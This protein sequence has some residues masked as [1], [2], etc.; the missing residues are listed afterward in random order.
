MRSGLPRTR[1][2]P[3]TPMTRP[4]LRCLPPCCPKSD[5]FSHPTR[6]PKVMPQREDLL[7]SI[8]KCAQ[9]LGHP[10]SRSEFMAATGISE[11]QVLM[12]FPSWTEAGRT[13]GLTPDMT[14][15]RLEDGLLLEDW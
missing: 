5:G 11:Y 9:S 12:H 7:E 14:N 13:A 1:R 6:A 15:V 3:R 4:L 8:R 10:P 2:R